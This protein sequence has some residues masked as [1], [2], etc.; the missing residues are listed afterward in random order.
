MTPK[1]RARTDNELNNDHANTPTAAQ[2]GRVVSPILRCRGYGTMRP[3][4]ERTG[5][6]PMNAIVWS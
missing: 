6:R 3:L 5:S 1:F 2:I 4:L